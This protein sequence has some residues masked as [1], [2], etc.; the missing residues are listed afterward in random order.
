M[1]ALKALHDKYPDSSWYM[2]TDDDSYVNVKSILKMFKVTTPTKIITLGKLF[3]TKK[4]ITT[5]VL[6]ELDTF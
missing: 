3:L 5:T 1:N 4:I 6:V 2:K